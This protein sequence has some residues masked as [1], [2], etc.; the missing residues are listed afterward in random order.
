MTFESYVYL[1]NMCTIAEQVVLVTLFCEIIALLWDDENAKIASSLCET[2][3]CGV[4][5]MTDVSNYMG[6]VMTG[7]TYAMIISFVIKLLVMAAH[8]S[9]A[10]RH[11]VLVNRCKA[12]CRQNLSADD[13][14]LICQQYCRQ[15][16]QIC[17]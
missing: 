11:Q 8:L 4:Y 6:P 13:I 16:R 14:C 3:L 12:A 9:A 10:R 5:V 17:P 1:H 7:L 2:A 15:V